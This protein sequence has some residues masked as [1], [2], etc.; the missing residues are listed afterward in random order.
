MPTVA[1]SGV[2]PPGGITVSQLALG[3]LV[4]LVVTAIGEPPL[5]TETVCVGGA[6][7]LTVKV[8]DVGI[9]VNVGVGGG[10]GVVTAG[11]IVKVFA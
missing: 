2:L 9:A 4:A 7:P 11:V 6:A 8:N 1:V 5:V 3:V 10:G